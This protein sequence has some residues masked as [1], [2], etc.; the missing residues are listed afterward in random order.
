MTHRE[1]D[2]YDEVYDNDVFEKVYLPIGDDKSEDID[3]LIERERLGDDIY[4]PR[5]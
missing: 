1:N 5:S 3:R 4:Y 2:N